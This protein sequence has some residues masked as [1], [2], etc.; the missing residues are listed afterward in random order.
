MALRAHECRYCVQDAPEGSMHRALFCARPAPSGPYC[1]G[2][3]QVCSRPNDL[4]L[5]ALAAEVAG[6]P[7]V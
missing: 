4:D 6:A 2:H 7:G 5:D 3:A 1:R